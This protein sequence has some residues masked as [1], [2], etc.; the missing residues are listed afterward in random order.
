MRAVK[1][2]FDVNSRYDTNREPYQ[3]TSAMAKKAN[4]WEIEYTRLLQMKLRLEL[5]RGTSRLSL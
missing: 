3:N 5:R 2:S 4:D 1:N